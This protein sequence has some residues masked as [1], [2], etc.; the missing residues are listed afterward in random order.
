MKKA[1]QEGIHDEIINQQ[2]I[3]WIPLPI[4]WSKMNVNG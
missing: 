3:D 4:A 2:L 1:K